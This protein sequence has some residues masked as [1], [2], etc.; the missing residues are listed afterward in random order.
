MKTFYYSFILFIYALTVNAQTAEDIIGEWQY[1]SLTVQPGTKAGAQEAATSIMSTMGLKLNNDKTYTFSLMGM[2]ENGKWDIK[3][4]AIEFVS[5]QASGSG[6]NF[7]ILSVEKNLLTLD[8]DQFKVTLS[9][10]GSDVP[11]PPVVKPEK[12]YTTATVP[13]LTK[14]WYLKQ[15]PAPANLTEAQMEAFA[16]S[17]S[18]SYIEFKTNG[19]CTL[20]LGDKKE[21]GQWNVNDKNNGVAVTLKNLPKELFFTKVTP[22]DLVVNEADNDDVWIF[23]TTE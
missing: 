12:I 18:G 20:Q 11:P 1:Y 7:P 17:L 5:N 3:N 22:T 13:Q 23:S 15:R 2:T 14:K 21:T 16:E 10:V 9:R 6:Y 4:K 8:K 19:K